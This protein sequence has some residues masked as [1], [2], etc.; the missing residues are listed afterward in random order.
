[1]MLRGILMEHRN[2]ITYLNLHLGFKYRSR[3]CRHVTQCIKSV[4][5]EEEFVNLIHLFFSDV[6]DENG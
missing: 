5:K 1:M 6:H 4:S 3:E 2:K